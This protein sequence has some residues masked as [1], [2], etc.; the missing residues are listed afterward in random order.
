MRAEERGGK[1]PV[2]REE[3]DVTPFQQVVKV[4]DSQVGGQQL[5]VVRRVSPLLVAQLLRKEADRDWPSFATP[6]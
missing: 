6:L 3:D 4:K 5:T 2:V 1:R